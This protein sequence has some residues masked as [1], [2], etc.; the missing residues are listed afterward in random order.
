MKNQWY[1]EWKQFEWKSIVYLINSFQENYD[2]LLLSSGSFDI[3]NTTFLKDW[4]ITQE[5][6]DRI[7]E[8]S[9]SKKALV[10]F[11]S[12]PKNLSWIL[13]AAKKKDEEI[14][15]KENSQTTVWKAPT[16]Q[17]QATVTTSVSASVNS[18]ASAPAVP[19]PKPTQASVLNSKETTKKEYKHYNEVYNALVNFDPEVASALKNFES[20]STVWENSKIPSWISEVEKIVAW[21]V[22]WLDDKWEK[23]KITFWANENILVVGDKDW[24]KVVANFENWEP[25]YSLVSE[26]GFSVKM[27]PWFE[28]DEKVL[29]VRWDFFQKQE[30]IKT[31]IENTLPTYYKLKNRLDELNRITSLTESQLQEKLNLEKQIKEFELKI[32]EA[33][34]EAE[35][36]TEKFKKDM[37][38]QIDKL[39]TER[40]KTKARN[41]QRLYEETWLAA[42]PRNIVDDIFYQIEVWAIIPDLWDKTKSFNPINI[43]LDRWN[44]W[45]PLWQ[46]NEQKVDYLKALVNKMFTWSVKW[47]WLEQVNVSN[48]SLFTTDFGI[49]WNFQKIK[50]Q[51]WEDLWIIWDMWFNR[52]KLLAN[53]KKPE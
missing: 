20:P 25:N 29:E 5:T 24:W 42:L 37:A 33:K 35:K 28:S 22:L 12:N 1:L 16:V 8:L 53:L 27:N 51:L 10:N 17:Q 40:E 39:N 34:K 3:K 6:L 19:Q 32:N 47:E 30:A 15:K 9:S 48:N 41:L 49:S 2:K 45:E 4:K 44:F 11:L 18:P 26:N 23:S 36:I 7:K 21:N 46:G 31:Q 52:E 43:D 13:A 38:N 50:T 14:F